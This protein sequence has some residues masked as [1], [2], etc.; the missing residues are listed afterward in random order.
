MDISLSDFA[1]V[2]LVLEKVN[3]WRYLTKPFEEHYFYWSGG[4]EADYIIY[5]LGL[6]PTIPLVDLLYFEYLHYL[7][8]E[9]KAKEVHIY[10]FPDHTSPSQKES[11]YDELCVHVRKIFGNTQNRVKFIGPDIL[12]NYAADLFT[13]ELLEAL[14]YIGS[15]EFFKYLNLH[16]KWKGSDIGD[17]NKS[18]EQKDK[19]KSLFV[20]LARG[21]CIR[22]HL[23]DGIFKNK[24]GKVALGFLIWQDEVD[25]LGVVNYMKEHCATNMAI[26]PILG[27]NIMISKKNPVPTFDHEKTVCL[28]DDSIKAIKMIINKTNKELSQY[29]NIMT[30]I[31]VNN[32]TVNSHKQMWN[33]TIK[34]ELI[35]NGRAISKRYEPPDGNNK[36]KNKAYITL[37]LLDRM[38]KIYNA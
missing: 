37:G 25:K 11:D 24:N 8:N 31:M 27:K 20:H 32:I 36:I 29:I 26:I 16:L 4:T 19:L 14:V 22:G 23:L 34:S 28:F 21:W 13:E 3:G 2:K 7:L 35:K 1:Q 12:R 30:T 10:A 18:R 5:Q 15:D 17:F 38:R 33:A 6:R 9:N